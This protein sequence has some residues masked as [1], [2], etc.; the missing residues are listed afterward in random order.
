M[1]DD[2]RM[3]RSL[4]RRLIRITVI[5]GVGAIASS[6]GAISLGVHGS[7]AG[8]VVFGFLALIPGTISVVVAMV[9]AGRIPLPDH[10][11]PWR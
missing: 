2:L 11:Q 5:Q 9:L 1:T 10:S 6:A 8:A 3:S 4:H 7:V